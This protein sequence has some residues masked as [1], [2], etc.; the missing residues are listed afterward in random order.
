MVRLSMELWEDGGES[1]VLP[2]GESGL[3]VISGLVRVR[4]SIRFAT[5]AG[6]T[7]W[8]WAEEGLSGVEGDKVSRMAKGL[9]AGEPG[10]GVCGSDFG[11][12]RSLDVALDVA[13][14]DA[15]GGDGEQEGSREDDLERFLW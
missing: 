10:V 15:G 3:R 2:E 7:A 13:G 1:F 8:T 14:R 4:A 5:P 11:L 9:R 12:E 6:G